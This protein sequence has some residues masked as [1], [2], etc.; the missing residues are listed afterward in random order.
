MPGAGNFGRGAICRRTDGSS[1][2]TNLPR[3]VLRAVLVTAIVVC[4]APAIAGADASVPQA[5]ATHFFPSR[6]PGAVLHELSGTLTDFSVGNDEGGF[7]IRSGTKT[8]E[9]YVSERFLINGSPA[10]CDRAPRPGEPKDPYCKWPS[11]IVVGKTRVATAYWLQKKQHGP[12]YVM[13]ASEF[14]TLPAGSDR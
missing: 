4:R 2:M 7:Q 9:I 6:P 12:E 13:V 3:A 8:Y 11:T 10:P 1:S 5:V 14:H